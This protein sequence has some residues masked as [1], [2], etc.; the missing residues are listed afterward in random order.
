MSELAK[1][2]V[3][4][5]GLPHTSAKWKRDAAAMLAAQFAGAVAL[6]GAAVAAWDP[7]AAEAAAG[8]QPGAAAAPAAA[9]AVAVP[10]K[11]LLLLLLLLVLLLQEHKLLLLLLLLLWRLAK[12]HVASRCCYC[13]C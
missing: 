1:R 9:V 10:T 5:A 2:R 11:L 3:Q 8:A 6:A 4:M 13:C 12:V 7:R